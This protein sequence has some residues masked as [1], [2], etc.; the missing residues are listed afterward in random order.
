MLTVPQA[1]RRLGVD[2]KTL[3]KRILAGEVT[4]TRTGK[5]VKSHWRIKE[6]DFAEYERSLE[7]GLPAA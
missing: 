7:V 6:E 4:A 3:R 2:P 5:G 1:A